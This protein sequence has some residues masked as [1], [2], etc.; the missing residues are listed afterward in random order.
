[1]F[2][3][4]DFLADCQA[5]AHADEAVLAIREVLDRAVSQPRELADAL[6]ATQAELVRLHVADD[7]TVLKAVWAPGM[8][9]RAHNHLM[10]A[11]IALYQGDEDNTFYRRVNGGIEVSGGRLIQTGEVALLGPDVIHAVANPGASLSAAIHVYGGNLTART[12]RSEWDESDAEVP[13]DF[14]RTLRYFEEANAAL[15]RSI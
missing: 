12:D 13:M 5:A 2:D 3:L 9:I 1:M 7:L 8:Q 6:P 10:W 14:E 11:A 4:D 15:G